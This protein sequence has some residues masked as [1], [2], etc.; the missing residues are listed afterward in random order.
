MLRSLLQTGSQICSRHQ[1]RSPGMALSL[2]QVLAFVFGKRKLNRARAQHEA[3][4]KPAQADLGCDSG[5]RN[6]AAR[7]SKQ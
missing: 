4:P 6:V 5:T 7:G 2:V 3:S 1:P